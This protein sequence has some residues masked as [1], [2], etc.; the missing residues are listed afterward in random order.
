[1]AIQIKVLLAG[2]EFL[3][4]LTMTLKMEMYVPQ[5]HQYTST[6]LQRVTTQKIILFKAHLGFL[7]SLHA[8]IEP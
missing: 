1:M 6:E 3:T 7:Q 8:G 5:K 2:F 4:V